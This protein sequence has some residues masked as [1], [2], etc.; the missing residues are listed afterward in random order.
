MSFPHRFDGRDLRWA[1]LALEC[2]PPAQGFSQ[3]CKGDKL[4]NSVN[5]KHDPLTEAEVTCNT[6]C[7]EASGINRKP[8]VGLSRKH[9]GNLCCTI[10]C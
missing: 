8:I 4:D 5:H 10:S 3:D 7:V 6:T 1:C 2:L 9:D